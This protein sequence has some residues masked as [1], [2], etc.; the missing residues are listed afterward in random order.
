MAQGKNINGTRKTRVY[1][2]TAQKL[3]MQSRKPMKEENITL[4]E[5]EIIRDEIFLLHKRRKKDVIDEATRMISKCYDELDPGNF[6][7]VLK[8]NYMRRMKIE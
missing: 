3:M 1:N 2:S 8:I 5:R 6:R 4:T 7:S